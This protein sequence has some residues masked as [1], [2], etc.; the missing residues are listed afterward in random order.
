M[1]ALLL[2]KCKWSWKKYQNNENK[3]KF[4]KKTVKISCTCRKKLESLVML[5]KFKGR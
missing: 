3:L 4:K 2:Q 1:A 5:G